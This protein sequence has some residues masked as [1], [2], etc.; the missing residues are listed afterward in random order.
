MSCVMYTQLC[1]AAETISY[2]L[3]SLELHLTRKFV[4]VTVAM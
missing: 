2:D 3:M 1:P 4:L